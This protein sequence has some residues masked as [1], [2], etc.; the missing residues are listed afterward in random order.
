MTTLILLIFILGVLIFVH[1]LGHFLAA[2]RAGV[3]IYEFALGFGPKIWSK[4]GKKDKITYSIR[5]LPIG[6]FVQ[7]AGEVFEDDNKIPKNK[8]MCNKPW[9]SRLKIISA[10][11]INNFI[12]A[13]I[14]LFIY[15]LIWGYSEPKTIVG[16]VIADY[17]A[18]LA[19][20]EPGD[21]LLKLNGKNV[22]SWKMFNI[23]SSFNNKEN[24]Y[25]ILVRKVDGREIT[26]KL[27][28][29]EH[30]EKDNTKRMIF[31]FDASDKMYKGFTNAIKYAFSEFFLIIE[32]MWFTIIGL[33]NGLISLNNLA[34][35]VG[36]YS[37]VGEASKIGISGVLYLMALLSINL[38]FINFLPFPAFDGGRA[39]F[40]VIE[41]IIGKPIN[42]KI[43][44]IIHAIF[45]VLL[46]I[47]M[48]Y[49]TI[50]DIIRLV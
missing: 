4:V 40:L 8:F 16:S 32:T 9:F 43:E 42:S 35:P 3:H 37:F 12:L 14:I 24:E 47:L 27:A 23:K 6:G 13:I 7:M 36:M 46:M 25:E 26:Y 30:V 15:A 39:L 21:Q 49:I 18:A 2:K 1:E 11:V 22:S 28:K 29:K 41:K 38:G 5:M 17:P 20:I 48:L 45:F 44:N 10:G 33:F 19:G 31:G 50:Q 34:G